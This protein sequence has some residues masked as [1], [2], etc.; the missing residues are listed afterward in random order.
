[1][2]MYKLPEIPPALL[3]K[4]KRAGK[5][6]K[7]KKPEFVKRRFLWF[8]ILTIFVSSF[9][10]F[11]AG[12]LSRI[13]LSE[14]IKVRFGDYLQELK[15]GLE[16]DHKELTEEPSL[17]ENPQENPQENPVFLTQEEQVVKVVKEVSPSVVSIIITKDLPIFEEYY[18]EPFE[19]FFGQPFEFRVPQYRQKGTEKKQIGGGTGFIVS[20]DGLILTNKHVVMDE[21][22]DYT[23]FT[24]EGQQFEAKVLARDPAQDL[25]VLKI[26]T[27]EKFPVVD[28]GNS[29]DLQIGQ[30]VVAIGNV[31]GEFRNSVSV[32]VIAGLG[33]SITA[34]GGGFYETLEDVIQTDAA[35]N[36][37]NS[38][39]PL[40]NL[41][42]QV[43]GINTAMSLSAE[44]IGFAI[45][46]NKAKKDVEQ[47]K[48]LGKI[49][50]PFLGIYY[51]LITPELK[52]QYSLPVNYGVWVG[53]DKLGRRTEVAIFEGSAAQE[54]GL[55]RDDIILE[56][57]FKKIT[58]EN[59]LAK[60]IME[61]NPGDRVSLKILRDEQEKILKATLEEKSG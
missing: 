11:L 54:A 57:N 6:P 22:A 56:F 37:G 42:G 23:A 29:D 59:S 47:V 9:F 18:L 25:A 39:G 35:I 33:R 7:I 34:S 52:E 13:F 12:A 15:K 27:E 38:G 41:K 8:L 48:T 61:Y 1:M 43:I 46:V 19:E 51:T 17:E 4:A 49:V 3:R 14:E 5:L 31:L 40:L 16:L 55:E 50:Y 60:I 32:G 21:T 30:T 10:G 45:P 20:E 36:K 2:P 53:R 24:N 26:E 28:L 58:L 44:N